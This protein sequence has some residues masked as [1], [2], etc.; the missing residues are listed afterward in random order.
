MIPTENGTNFPSNT[1][2]RHQRKL[3]VDFNSIA[4]YITCIVIM[5]QLHIYQSNIL[6]I[7]RIQSNLSMK[8]IVDIS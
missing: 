3:C 5:T 4:W 1:L 2:M 7:Y 6:M 8:Y